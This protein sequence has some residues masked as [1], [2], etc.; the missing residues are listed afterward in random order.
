MN[1]RKY[2]HGDLRNTL[3]ETS[4]EIMNREGIGKLTLRKTALLCGVSQAAPYSHF[5]NKED[6]LRAMQDHVIEQFME[7]LS[8]AILEC[9]DQNSP[10]MLI[11]LGKEYVT[12]FI[13][14]PQYF[15]FIFSQQEIVIDL[16]FDGDA[17][18][19]FPPFQLFKTKAFSILSSLGMSESRV[20]DAVISMWATVHGLASIATMKNVY[21]DKDWETKIVE[22]ISN[23][24]YVG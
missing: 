16:S 2:H 18:K 10:Q 15:S 3:I 14:N 22:I 11:Q 4:I 8:N 13:R 19:N 9:M 12:F 20:E 6:M 21:Y 5:A 23:K 17:Q 24:Q 7:I 1:K